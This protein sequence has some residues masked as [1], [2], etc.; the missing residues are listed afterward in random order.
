[1]NELEVLGANIKKYRQL[2]EL[3]QRDLAEKIGM[4]MEY[5]SKIERGSK[6]NPGLKNLISISQELNIELFQLFLENPDMIFIKLIISDKNFENLKR[7]VDEIIKRL[8][9]KK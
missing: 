3:L 4:S 8:D 6:P 7:L 1:M 5:L 2:K 9:D